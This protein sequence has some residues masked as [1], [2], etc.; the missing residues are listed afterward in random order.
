MANQPVVSRPV[1]PPRPVTP[2]PG[3]VPKPE[4]G[5]KVLLIIICILSIVV[6]TGMCGLVLYFTGA[7]SDNTDDDSNETKYTERDVDIEKEEKRNSQ[8]TEKEER[9]E[10]EIEEEIT[11]EEEEEPEEFS[12]NYDADEYLYPTHEKNITKE[13]LDMLTREEVSLVRNEIYARHGYTFSTQ[14]YTDFF[15]T[16]DWYD[17]DPYLTDGAYIEDSLNFYE[18]TNKDFIVQYEKEM[19]WR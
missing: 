16:K 18:K 1:T 3:P 4:K 19:G 7:F 9:E 14:S 11:E 17:P 6:V 10:E 12:L 2:A 8:E 15:N 13:E 5:S